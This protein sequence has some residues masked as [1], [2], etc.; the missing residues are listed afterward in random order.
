MPTQFSYPGVYIEEIESSV[1]PI[2]GVETSVTAFVGLALKG[3]TTPTAV[4]SWADFEELF[5]G[6]WAGSDMSYAVFQFFLNGGTQA[7]VVRVGGEVTYA[8]VQLG[9]G[10]D[11]KAKE[12]GKAG[13]AL[14]ATVTHDAN[15]PMG[16]TLVITGGARDE[17]YVVSIDPALPGRRLDVLLGTSQ[18]V[19]PDTAVF[20]QRPTAAA[21]QPFIGG[22]DVV[23]TK[24]DVLGTAAAVP[25]TGLEA[26]RDVD[27]FNLL[28]IPPQLPK[29]WDGTEDS[30]WAPVIDAA[31][32][33]CEQR[34][35]MLLLDPPFAWKTAALAVSGA[36]AGLPVAGVA[37]RNAA[38]F[39]PQI[40]ISDPLADKERVVGP[41]GT[42]AGVIARTDGRRGIWKAPAGI[43]DGG[44]VGVRSLAFRLTDAQNGDLNQLGVNCLRTFPVHGRVLWGSRTCRGADAIGDPWKYIPVRRVALHIEESLFVGTKW[45]VFEPNDEPLW[46]SIRLNVGTFMDRLFRQGAFQGR[47]AKEAYFVRCDATNNPQSDI[48]LGIVNI[49]VGFQPLKPAEFVLIRIQQK[50]PDTT[51][52]GS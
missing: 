28:V 20:D 10:V 23:L 41:A 18:L 46:S 16:Y 9:S 45:V 32:L 12:P 13:E 48:D 43:D 24:Q 11:L 4:E 39:F 49:D 52:Q 14:K 6:L 47:T 5:G 42:V 33:L 44:L 38:V 36:R 34:R 31:A 29:P 35:A 15:D 8:G 25:R 30:K 19:E 17:T 7:V 3:P 27:I 2:T 51:V 22:Q 1:R 40:S 26:L 21:D 37:G 50:L